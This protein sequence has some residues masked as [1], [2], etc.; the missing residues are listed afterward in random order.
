MI[1]CIRL[2]KFNN[3]KINENNIYNFGVRT[4]EK[5][6]F[7]ILLDE[8]EIKKQD[9]ICKS[10]RRSM[11][12]R[13]T[14]M[15]PGELDIINFSNIED[16][17]I[18]S[19]YI[20]EDNPLKNEMYIKL[21]DKN[22]YILSNKYALKYLLLKQNELKKIF[23]LLGAKKIKWSVIK[24]DNKTTNIDASLGII[25]NEINLEEKFSSTNK[26]SNINKE[27]NE[28]EFDYDK[29]TI[30]NINFDIFSDNKFYFLP[31]EY[32][33]Q[34][35]V[36]RRLE[37]HL[38]NDK[39]VYK[40]TNNIFFERTLISKLH[41]LNVNFNY[42]MNELDDIEIHYEIEYYPI[43]KNLINKDNLDNGTIQNKD[44]LS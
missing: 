9:Y 30:N 20:I 35:I 39:Y 16:D 28:M 31:K 7:L 24:Q 42:N 2:N 6:K 4:N 17:N 29:D 12:L 27:F 1:G 5:L 15:I 22:I 41:F 19:N 37:N 8:N 33:W 43:Q 18:I 13:N 36:I 23:I 44:N 40:Y 14:K 11:I 38:I 21:P 10:S 26:N 3:D 32:E 34:D 25:I